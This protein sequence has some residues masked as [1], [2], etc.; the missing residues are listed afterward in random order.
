M[1]AEASDTLPS[2]G[3]PQFNVTVIAG[4]DKVCT[5]MVEA[6]VLYCFAMACGTKQHIII[7]VIDIGTYIKVYG[8]H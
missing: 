6:D 2:L 4:T 5:I 8:G 7:P 3:V 1:I